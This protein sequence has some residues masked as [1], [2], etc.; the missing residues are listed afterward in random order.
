MSDYVNTNCKKC[1][2]EE[3]SKNNILKMHTVPDNI[4]KSD[5]LNIIFFTELMDKNIFKKVS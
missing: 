1:I 2:A 4:I 3:Y 5:V